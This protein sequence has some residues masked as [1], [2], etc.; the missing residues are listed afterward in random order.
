M[1]HSQPVPLMAGVL[2]LMASRNRFA[3]VEFPSNSS[4]PVSFATRLKDVRDIC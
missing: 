4:H 1:S 2:P 3:S